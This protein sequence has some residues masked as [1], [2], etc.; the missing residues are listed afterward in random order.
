MGV[1]SGDTAMALNSMTGFASA[2]GAEGAVSWRWELRSVNARGLDI[3]VRLPSGREGLEPKLRKALQARLKRGGVTANLQTLR[4]QDENALRLDADALAAA[5]RA[6]ASVRA[7]AEAAGLETAPVSIDGLMQVRGVLATG[8]EEPDPE[9]VAA[10]E[11]AI[12]ASLEE[13][14]ERLAAARAVEGEALTGVISSQ[15]DEIEV[16]VTAAAASAEARSESAANRLREKVDALLE[17]GADMSEDRLAQEL[18]LLAVKNDVREEI[19]RLSAHVTGARKLLQDAPPIGRKLDFLCQEFNR[20]ANTLC[21]KSLSEE[22]TRI[23][24]ALKVVIDQ[25][26]EQV[27]NV[28]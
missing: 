10:L 26:R 24:L 6:A 4:G 17:A 16:L 11:A 12:M 18:A 25:M 20:E 7:A 13:A 28:E 23:G 19:D 3:R 22:L 9:A 2:E 21:S 5:L 14:V 15:V 1:Y 8:A 27:Q